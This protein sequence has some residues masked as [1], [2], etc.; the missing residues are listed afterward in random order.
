MSSYLY[1]R[2]QLLYF[3][4]SNAIEQRWSFPDPFDNPIIL[5]QTWL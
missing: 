2:F 5:L 1:H 3:F 4:N